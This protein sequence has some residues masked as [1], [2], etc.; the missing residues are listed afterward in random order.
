MYYNKKWPYLSIAL[1][2][3]LLFACQKNFTET[4]S[5]AKK[6]EI[7]TPQMLAA[8]MDI[9]GRTLAANCFQCHGTNGYASE[10]KIAGINGAALTSKFAE[11]K[12]RGARDNIMNVHAY[13]YTPE[14][15]QLMGTYFSKQ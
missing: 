13:A 15:I 11:M 10:L 6:S 3:P 5:A 9:P 1:A 8:T 4:E 14:E 12:A 2:L 7:N